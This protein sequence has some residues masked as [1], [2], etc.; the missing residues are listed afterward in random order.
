MSSPFSHEAVEILERLKVPFYKIPSG[1]VTNL[2]LLRFVAETGKP[3]FLSS[4]MSTWDELDRAVNTILDH[5]SKLTILQCTSVYPCPPQMV[6][7]NVMLEMKERYHLPV[8]L[9]DHSMSNYSALAAVA[10]GA[11][12]IEKHLTFSRKMYGTD[13]KHSLEPDEFLQFDS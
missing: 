3:V 7:L 4:G 9:S 1:E 11:S 5:H 6:G 10:L 8:G 13:A 12:V 2:S